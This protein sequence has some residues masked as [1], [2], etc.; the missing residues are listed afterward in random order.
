MQEQGIENQEAFEEI[1]EMDMED[2]AAIDD[3]A[4]QYYAETV[5][6]V[7]DARDTIPREDLEPVEKS[8]KDLTKAMDSYR[9]TE[10]DC[11]H[12]QKKTWKGYQKQHQEN[13]ENIRQY[14]ETYQKGEALPVKEAAGKKA[15][16]SL[17]QS[18]AYFETQRK[19]L[20]E[21]Y[22]LEIAESQKERK[23]LQ[24]E[25]SRLK[26]VI[27]DLRESARKNELQLTMGYQECVAGY[28]ALQERV[29]AT[30]KRF[31][32]VKK[33]RKDMADT[34][35]E[36]YDKV[37]DTPR[38]VKEAVENT[39]CAVIDDAYTKTAG[40]FYKTGQKIDQKRDQT[41]EH[42]RYWTEKRP[43]REERKAQQRTA[44]YIR[45]EGP[46]RE[47]EAVYT[48]AEGQDRKPLS[49]KGKAAHT[50]NG[51]KE[52]VGKAPEESAEKKAPER[53]PYS[54]EA[55]QELLEELNQQKQKL[56]EDYKE[57]RQHFQHTDLPDRTESFAIRDDM[58]PLEI[59]Q[60]AQVGLPE[61]SREQAPREEAVNV[62]TA[63]KTTKV[64]Q[65][66]TVEKKEPKR[67]QTTGHDI[68]K[69]PAGRH[70]VK[71]GRKGP[72]RKGA[73]R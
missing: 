54:R 53:D 60:A 57:W 4:E 6:E 36:T 32:Y 11:G 43:E 5:R 12:P 24:E 29:E 65:T 71:N 63:E 15:T 62:Q 47:E 64:Q 58:G 30:Q 52:G 69:P 38:R 55:I 28:E 68:Q 9:E 35:K 22:Q 3:M 33:F 13:K 50:L 66:V 27:H 56:Q 42:T 25:V 70:Y 21:K 18:A 41:L 59:M 20:Q 34:I 40:V 1:Q 44:V 45:A 16:E 23:A 51:L 39:A 61:R 46:E 48:Q 26:D 17:S 2:W 73:E 10:Q 7:E 8:A 37:K 31:W 72:D 19:E 67:T 49:E 14:R